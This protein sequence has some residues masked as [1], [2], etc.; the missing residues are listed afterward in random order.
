MDQCKNHGNLHPGNTG[1]LF[2]RDSAFGDPQT[3][4]ELELVF[5]DVLE[6]CISW[7]AAKI[8]C[9]AWPILF[10]NLDKKDLRGGMGMVGGLH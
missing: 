1:D 6:K 7:K 10:H 3:D 9:S 4:R 8:P 2:L 5:P